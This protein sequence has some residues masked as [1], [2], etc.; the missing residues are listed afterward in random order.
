MGNWQNPI[1]IV[2]NQVG[3]IKPRKYDGGGERVIFEPE[4]LEALRKVLLSEISVLKL[5]FQEALTKN[6]VPPVAHVLL[7]ADALA[8][9]H[10]PTNLLTSTSCPII[11]MES[12]GDLLIAL[13]SKGLAKLERRIKTDKS[14]AGRAAISTITSIRPHSND[15][16]V[17][18]LE[19][20]G[21]SPERKRS[22]KIKLFRYDIWFSDLVSIDRFKRRFGAL[23]LEAPIE[24]Q[25]GLDSRVF[26]ARDISLEDIQKLSSFVGIQS[27][28]SLPKYGI[29]RQSSIRIRRGTIDDFPPPMTDIDYP[30]VGL[31]DSGIDP[32]N[33]LLK[34]W[35]VQRHD[36][37]TPDLYDYCHG[38]FVGA[39][40]VHADKLNGN[41]E[42]MRV[43]SCK[44]VDVAAIPAGGAIDELELMEIIRAVVPLHPEVRYWN[45]SLA[46]STPCSDNAFSDFAHFLDEMQREFSTTFVA[47]V[48]NLVSKPLR[49]WP[50]TDSSSDWDRVCPPA[51]SALSVTVG[52]IAHLAKPTSL[53][54][55]GQPSPFSRRGPATSALVSPRLVHYGGNCDKDGVC[56]Q[57]GILSLSPDGHICENIGTSMATPLVTALLASAVHNV[58]SPVSINLAK[59][60]AFHGAYLASDKK[61]RSEMAYYGFGVPPSIS[62][63]LGCNDWSATLVFELSLLSNLE[64]DKWPFP[65]PSCLRNE[66]GS[67]TGELSLTLVYDPPLDSRQGTEYCRTNVEASLGTYDE[68]KKGTRRQKGKVPMD[69][70]NWKDLYEK[71]QVEEF[72]KWSP[73]KVYRKSFRA[74][75]G[76]DWRLVVDISHRSNFTPLVPQN[77]ALVVTI[78]DPKKKQPVYEEVTKL[79][80]ELGW[81][82]EELEVSARL[83][84]GLD[85]PGD[86]A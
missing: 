50:P 75:A 20:D 84:I 59:A 31:I 18:R 58:V 34:P 25:Y 68:D 67:F 7:R 3:D 51:D 78:S 81:I 56:S 1:K 76:Q 37:V 35:V 33:E 63:I 36:F 19:E 32:D 41:D 11:G 48:G 73:V 5:E 42:R 13:N 79:M 4:K 26:V 9:S 61:E 52:S 49:Q 65:I 39:L 29:L 83:R 30:I 86:I 82:T 23:D 70:A 62:G 80:S 15:A 10:R 64:F 72:F 55:V 17:K 71:V 16:S 40:L 14:K 6:D 46:T 69:R 85:G 53:A 74:A 77:V 60:L 21:G 8:K 43:G 22:V 66:E 44:I 57:V 28:E 47:A 27:I 2:L 38:T 12:P 45:M 24:V 54:K